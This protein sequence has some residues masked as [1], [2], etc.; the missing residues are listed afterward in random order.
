MTCHTVI[1]AQARM[2]STRLPGKVMMDLGGR[3]VIEHV[4]ERALAVKRANALVIATPDLPEDESLALHVRS[5]GVEV[6][7]GSAEDVLSRYAKA[8]RAA[9]ADV[10]VR[11]TC[12]CP[13]IDPA[14]IDESIEA[15]FSSGADYCTNALR[16]TYP[17]GM[18]VE[19]LK[20]AAV[21]AAESEATEKQHREHVTPFI[22]QHAERFKLHNVEAPAWA[23]RP[24]LRL[25]VDEPADLM[26]LRELLRRSHGSSLSL[27]EVLAVVDGHPELLELNAGVMHRYVEKPATW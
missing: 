15:F 3:P 22:Y 14:V 20:V 11:I 27:R 19:V 1:I 13:L 6:V 23:T 18:D 24:E 25:T 26:F 9:Q 17:I 8:A 2:G 12:D 16:R 21:Y 5:L 10:V 4:L 7:Q